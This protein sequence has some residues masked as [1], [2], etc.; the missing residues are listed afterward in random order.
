MG[1]ASLV[2]GIVG[3]LIGLTW[4]KDLS[5][6]LCILAIVLGIIAIAKK[7]NKVI[8]IISVVIAVLGLVVVFKDDIGKEAKEKK[9]TEVVSKVKQDNDDE[10]KEEKTEAAEAEYEIGKA[11]FS[12]SKDS[13]DTKWLNVFVP[14]KNTGKTNLH[15]SPCSIDI[16]DNDGTI[17][18][19]L[20]MVFAYP[21]LIKPGETA[22]YY[23]NTSFDNDESNGL[24]FIP[25]P[26]VEKATVDCIRYDVSEVQIKDAK[27]SG[28]EA[29][30]RIENKTNEEANS[31]YVVVELFDAEKNIIGIVYYQDYNSLA[32]G[33]KKAFKAESLDSSLKASQVVSYRAYAYEAQYT[34]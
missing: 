27:Y 28:V 6:I 24:K 20:S 30:G 8:S 31:Y 33:D 7:K 29:L 18:D 34:F 13:I 15:L 22:Y 17:L 21:N 9:S 32:V 5:I 25:H 1:I 16:E 2:L 4:F 14:I 26:E 23:N 19:T 3:F 12:I 10:T 11:S